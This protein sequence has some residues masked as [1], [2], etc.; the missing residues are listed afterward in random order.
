MR[1][2]VSLILGRK[3]PQQPLA[4]STRLSVALVKALML[5]AF[6]KNLHFFIFQAPPE[7]PRRDGAVR[8]P[9][10]IFGNRF[11]FSRLRSFR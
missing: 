2:L 9:F 3:R 10:I 6:Q 4:E 11:H 7:V 1:L 5:I 8:M